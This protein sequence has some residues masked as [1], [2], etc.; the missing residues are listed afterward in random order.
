MCYII[1]RYVVDNIEI[2]GRYYRAG[3]VEYLQHALLPVHLHLLPVAV[4]YCRIVLLHKDALKI[5]VTFTTKL[6]DAKMLMLILKVHLGSNERNK[7][8]KEFLICHAYCLTEYNASV[9]SLHLTS[10]GRTAR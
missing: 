6:T 10:P 9:A 7:K 1:Y 3:G 8:M 5:N 4:L 2:C